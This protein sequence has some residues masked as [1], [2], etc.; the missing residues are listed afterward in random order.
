V[1][2]VKLCF[3]AKNYKLLNEN[4][5]LLSKRRS[6]IKQSITKM[7]EECCGYVDLFP[8]KPTQL[9]FI[10]TLRSITAGKV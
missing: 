2:I 9:E 1:A 3:E 7:I 4:I 10:D 6:Q 5:V 8:D